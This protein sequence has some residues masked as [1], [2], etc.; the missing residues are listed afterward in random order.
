MPYDNPSPV[1]Q[2]EYL[3][4]S[5]LG[6]TVGFAFAQMEAQR[7]EYEYKF[8]RDPVTGCLWKAQWMEQV[9]FEIDNLQQD[10]TQNHDPASQNTIAVIFADGTRIGQVNKVIDHVTGDLVIKGLGDS[11]NK[12]I[13]SAVS[14]RRQTDLAMRGSKEDDYSTGRFGGDEF[15]IACVIPKANAEEVAKLIGERVR[16]NFKDFVLEARETV[17]DLRR[18]AVDV[19]VGH[20]ILE[21]D[22]S[23]EKLLIRADKHMQADKQLQYAVD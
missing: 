7:L 13:R 14:E 19:A 6:N 1:E 15:I 5:S 17:P 16:S 18:V 12:S 10:N 4:W 22:E 11:V 2:A 3:A 20:A 9:G 21:A 8:A 23:V